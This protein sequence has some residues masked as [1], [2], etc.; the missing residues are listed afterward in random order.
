MI[1]LHLHT[2]SSDGSDEPQLILK[3]AAHAGLR[4]ISITDHDSMEAYHKLKEGKHRESYPGV[5]IPGCEFSVVHNKMPIEVLGYGL[6]FDT[7]A[8]SGLLSDERFLERENQYIN[9]MKEICKNLGI[10]MTDTLSITSGKPF[11]TQVIHRD[12]RKY[13]EN[14]M[15]FSQEI[16]GSINAFYRTCINNEESPFFLNQAKDYPTVSEIAALIRKAGGKSFLAHLYG[17]FAENHLELLDSI[18]SLRALDGIECYHSL[19]D[20]EKTEFLLGYCRDNRLLA[21]GG[22]DYHGALKPSVFIGESIKGMR[23]PFEILE[24]WLPSVKTFSI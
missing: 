16:W 17:Y 22:S 15:F 18:V 11:A 20:K 4:Y 10:Q 1:D 2:T 7:I 8:E 12:L 21:S 5:L 3:K 24:P 14:E 13:P 6:D 9:K 19:H 23:I